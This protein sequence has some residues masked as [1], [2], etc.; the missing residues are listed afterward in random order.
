VAVDLVAHGQFGMMAALRGAEIVGV[1]LADATKTL[2]RL[3]PKILDTA[4]VFFG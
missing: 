2:K 4:Q 1:P 3:D